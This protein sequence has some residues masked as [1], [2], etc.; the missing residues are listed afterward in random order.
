MMNLLT[1]IFVATA[2]FIF[3]YLIWKR[4]MLF[5]IIGYEEKRF[6][7]DKNTLAK[8]VGYILATMGV[9]TLLVPI[10]SPIFGSVVMYIYVSTVIILVIVG[11]LFHTLPYLRI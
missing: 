10:M 4:K 9:L 1:S 7:G 3:S 6:F 2:F 8:R 11:S 5:L